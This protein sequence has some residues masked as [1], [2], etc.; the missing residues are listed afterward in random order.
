MKPLLKNYAGLLALCAA[1]LILETG[2]KNL[3][4]VFSSNRYSD[5]AYQTAKS[6]QEKSLALIDKAQG[7]AAYAAF[8]KEDTAL[9]QQFDSAIAAEQKRSKNQP[10]IEQWRTVKNQMRRF[11]DLWKKKEKLSPAFVMQEKKQVE[12]TFDTLLKTEQEKRHT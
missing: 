2:C 9:M 7:R 4:D 11:L 5:T 1:F 3:G 10:T 8:E 6:V 12:K